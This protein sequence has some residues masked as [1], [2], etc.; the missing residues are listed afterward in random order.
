MH[1][2]SF[3]PEFL[4][5]QT[6]DK[7]GVNNPQYG[8]VKSLETIAKLTKLVY[9]YDANTSELLGTYSTVNCA[10]QFNMGKNTL[11]KYLASGKPFKGLIFRRTKMIG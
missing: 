5:T 4:A 6:Q 2:R 3:S 1:G 9:V 7:T 8:V 10:K 11:T